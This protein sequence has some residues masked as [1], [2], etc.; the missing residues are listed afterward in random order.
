MGENQGELQVVQGCNGVIVTPS[1]PEAKKQVS[2]STD[3]G[4]RNRQRRFRDIC[5]VLLVLTEVGGV[6]GR[7]VPVEVKQ[8]REAHGTLHVLEMETEGGN[9]TGGTGTTDT[10]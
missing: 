2:P 5:G 4:S 7:W 1:L 3:L 6:Y 9:S 8:S 10:M